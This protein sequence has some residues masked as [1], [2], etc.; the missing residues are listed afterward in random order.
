M[1][2]YGS[3]EIEMQNYLNAGE[4]RALQINNR[5]PIRFNKD[6]SLNSEI[7]NS[8][9]QNGFYIFEKVFSNSE[10]KDCKKDFLD[11][12]KKF[13]ISRNSKIDSKGR[14]AITLECK[15]NILYMSQ[16]LADPFQ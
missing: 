11:L 8:Y 10:L 3:E 14:K 13:P 16:P 9:E 4:K 5:G 15:A 1:V 12:V 2:N 7:I 6:G